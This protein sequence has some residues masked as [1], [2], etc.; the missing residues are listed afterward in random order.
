MEKVMRKEFKENTFKDKRTS[1]KENTPDK[2]LLT[3]KSEKKTN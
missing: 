3:Q 1:R 2:F